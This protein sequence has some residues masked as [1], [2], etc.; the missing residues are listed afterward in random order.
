MVDHPDKAAASAQQHREGIPDH[1]RPHAIAKI[2]RLSNLALLVISQ[3][4]ISR[5]AVLQG[6]DVDAS[7]AQQFRPQFVGYLF[8]GCS[9]N[10]E[11]CNLGNG[12]TV[13]QPADPEVC[14]GR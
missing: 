5:V 8:I 10:R 3:H 11:R 13:L 4:Q 14:D 12:D 1:R 2:K 7:T 9:L 6:H